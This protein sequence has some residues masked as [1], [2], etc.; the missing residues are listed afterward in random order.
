[1]R[2]TLSAPPMANRHQSGYVFRKGTWWYVRFY[3]NVPTAD[4]RIIRRQVCRQ[5]APHCDRYRCRRDVMPLVEEM[6]KS[7]NSGGC[8]PESV[9]TVAQFI[10]D[11]YLKYADREKR[12]STSKGYRDIWKFHVKG[13]LGALRLRD[14]RPVDGERLIQDIAR[15]SEYR[16]SRTTLKHIK[17][18][19]SGVFTYARRQG[20]LSNAN[21][22]QGVS[23][24][25]GAEPA[26]LTHTRW[27]R[28]R[29][30]LRCCLGQRGSS[31]R[32][33]ASLVCGA[34]RSAV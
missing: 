2:G 25:R 19:L 15:S 20:V 7:V 34:P 5:I 33:P 27:S 22:M 10:E 30:C 29:G 28:S 6:L 11:H 9:L 14:F 32:P 31:S 8:L 17:S 21:P 1:M 16:L 24:P 26:T 23:I 13:R 18:F 3:D 4:G 12:A